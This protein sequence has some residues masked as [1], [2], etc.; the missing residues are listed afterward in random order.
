MEKRSLFKLTEVQRCTLIPALKQKDLLV[1]S[2]TGSGKTLAFII[3]IIE[4][5]Y[6][7]KWTN[8]DGLG[9]L[10]LVPTREL[11]MQVYEVL[12]SLLKEFHEMNFGLII[13]G[14]SLEEERKQI[15]QMN[16][17]IATPGRF[18]QHLTDS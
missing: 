8:L 16:I 17:L 5:L 1:S 9:A 14:K 10:I 4:N 7:Q 11:A 3:P 12:L 15:A 6:W 18:L 13:G 2:K